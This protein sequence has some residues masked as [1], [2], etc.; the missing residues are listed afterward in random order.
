MTFA[1]RQ[2]ESDPMGSPAHTCS[3]AAR[4]AP[5]ELNIRW[6]SALLNQL[7]VARMLGNNVA[8]KYGKLN[9]EG[10]PLKCYVNCIIQI[11]SQ[12]GSNLLLRLIH[13]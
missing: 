1:F 8:V 12:S 9:S 7:A 11:A 2:H 4:R 10:Q 6:S 13:D 3:R 5:S